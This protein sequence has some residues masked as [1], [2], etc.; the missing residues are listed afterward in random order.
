MRVMDNVT[1]K[2]R[3]KVEVKI[4]SDTMVQDNVRMR[5]DEVRVLL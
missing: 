3:I 2:V 4:R 1:V 5:V